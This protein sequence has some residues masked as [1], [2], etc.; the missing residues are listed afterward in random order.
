MMFLVK[1]LFAL[2]I[3]GPIFLAGIHNLIR[4]KAAI[5]GRVYKVL[6]KWYAPTPAE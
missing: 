3:V 2:I 5:V 4:R 1:A 6:G